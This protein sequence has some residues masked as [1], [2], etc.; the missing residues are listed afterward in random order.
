MRPRSRFRVLAVLAV[1]TASILAT[2]GLPTIAFAQ[3]PAMSVSPASGPPGQKVTLT[4]EGFTA[5][6]GSQVE[7][8]ISIDHGNGNWDLLV[9][10]AAYPVPDA[11]GHF[12]VSVTIPSN[13]PSGDLL[14]I[15]SIT[16]P[17][18]D[19]FFTVTGSPGTGA[20]VPAAPS[21]LTVKAVDPHNIRLNWHDN[22]SNETGFEINNGVVS[23][24]AGA[25][26]TSYTWGG[27]APGTYM[28]FKVRAYNNAGDSAWDPNVTPWYVCT[29]TPKSQP[30]KPTIYWSRT[31]GAPGTRFTLTGNG[32]TAGGS[33]RVSFPAKNLFYSNASWSVDSHGDW[34]QNFTVGDAPPGAYK[35][36]FSEA[37]GHLLVT[38]S[39]KVLVAPTLTGKTWDGYELDYGQKYTSVTA[40]WTEPKY[41][42]VAGALHRG[43]AAFWVGL[44]G[45]GGS[46]L[47]QIGTAVGYGMTFKKGN[48]TSPYYAWY[49][50]VPDSPNHP[51]LINEPVM[52]GDKFSATVTYGGRSYTLKLTDITRGWTFTQVI[53]QKYDTNSAEVVMESPGSVWPPFMSPVTFS[54]IKVNGTSMRNPTPLIDQPNAAHVGP[55]HDDSFT[56]YS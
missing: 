5:Y 25:N 36:S 9:A 23:R 3:S 53:H 35:L 40:E 10:G 30:A 6:T 33:V 22:S 12:S 11:N 41:P 52:P 4:G 42:A 20:S 28:C 39:F 37:S 16:E 13:A 50:T 18:A 7:V 54:G 46:H 31:S 44:G 14:A 1:I 55:F 51:A 27:L 56:A 38:G 29:T 49:E 32:W 17:E 45:V 43:L 47:Q 19:A 26:S 2:V 21:N 15:S 8:D 48:Q 24:D 34:Q